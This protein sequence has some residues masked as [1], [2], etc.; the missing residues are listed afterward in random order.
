MRNFFLF[1]KKQC[2]INFDRQVGIS[3]FKIQHGIKL[4]ITRLSTF[5]SR[6][7]HFAR[8]LI[9]CQELCQSVAL[10]LRGHARVV[11]RPTGCN[12]AGAARVAPPLQLGKVNT[13]IAPTALSYLHYQHSRFRGLNKLCFVAASP[14]QLGL[15]FCPGNLAPTP[16][17]DQITL[18]KSAFKSFFYPSPL[19]QPNPINSF[20]TPFSV[21]PP[22]PS[23]HSPHPQKPS[24]KEIGV[25]KKAAC[26][27]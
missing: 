12:A 8:F 27:P 1:Y 22:L 19:S 4:C 25:C 23:P 11:H 6:D 3:H 21:L 2:P 10:A 15:F 26:S 24:P 14:P 20:S 16:W 17:V 7:E 13:A 5:L 9:I 18:L